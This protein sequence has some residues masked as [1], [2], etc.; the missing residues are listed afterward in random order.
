MTYRPWG[1]FDWLD[2]KMGHAPWSVLGVSGTEDRC[3]ALFQALPEPMRPFV[4]ML[5]IED[6]SPLDPVGYGARLNEISDRLIGEGIAGEA[7]ATVPLLADVDSIREMVDAFIAKAG[8]RI[9]LDITAMPKWWFFPVIRFLMANDKIKTLIVTYGSATD[10]ATDLSAHPRPLG[11]LPTFGGTD[12]VRGPQELIVGI[13]FVPLGLADLYTDDIERVRYLF[14]FPPGP[15]YFLRNWGFLRE[16][17]TRIVHRNSQSDDRWHVHMYDCPSV[18]DA[19]TRF[20]GC[21]ERTSVLAPFGPKTI[22]LSMCLFALAV[23]AAGGDP[24][25]VLY[26]QPQR[27][28]LDYTKG[29]KMVDGRPDIRAYCLRLNGKN[30]YTLPL[31]G[32]GFESAP[33]ADPGALLGGGG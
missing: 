11:P 16:L 5:R 14:P 20:T 15:P 25:P 22:S 23:E 32:A 2:A 3:C 29:I 8:P 13:G 31:S 28:A 9:I 26:T 27:Y 1:P 7:F 21:G 30:L 17:Q 24:I 12:Y 19:L 6:P 4:H 18:F 10:Y 33:S